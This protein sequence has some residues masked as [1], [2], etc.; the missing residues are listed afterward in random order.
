MSTVDTVVDGRYTRPEVLPEGVEHISGNKYRVPIEKIVIADSG[1]N[2]DSP[3]LEFTN[4]RHALADYQ[5]KG[6]GFE[7]DETDR[8]Q[9]S[10]RTQGILNDPICRW[11]KNGTVQGVDCERRLRVTRKLKGLN[12]PCWDKVNHKYVPASELYAKVE[13]QIDSLSDFEAFCVSYQANE[14]AVH[15]G[16]GASIRFVAYMRSKGIV[17]SKIMQATG[18]DADW[19]ADTDKLI[20][21]DDDKLLLALHNEE[22]TR[23][24]ALRLLDT[25]PDANERS[26]KLFELKGIAEAR[27]TKNVEVAE[28]KV[29]KA[30]KKVEKI[31]AVDPDI[32]DDREVPV[33]PEPED[34]VNLDADEIALANIKQIEV[35]GGDVDNAKKA[36]DKFVADAENALTAAESAK[37]KKKQTERKKPKVLTRDIGGGD[38]GEDKPPKPL[39]PSKIEKFWWEVVT[40]LIKK[41]NVDAETGEE[42]EPVDMRDLKLTKFLCQQVKAGETDIIKILKK[43]KKAMDKE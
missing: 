5:L 2:L 32:I 43:F 30:E 9:E 3:T 42:I 37:A 14:D 25:F 17:D 38:D 4:M 23:P 34:T 22:I 12:T 11:F 8:L 39:S 6:N 13:V 19:L 40:A 29:Q 10:V 20:A 21:A 1:F 7:K 35:Q 27:Y 15:H 26:K 41:N 36:A 28:K 31:V 33:I 16:E 18:Y 24:A